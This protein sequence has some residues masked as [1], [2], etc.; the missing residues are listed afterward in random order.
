MSL[1][2]VMI[3]VQ[4]TTL[5]P[6]EREMLQHP[7][8]GGVIL[9]T[10]NYE[11]PEQIIE[12]VAQIHQQRSPH[13]LVA[14]D[15][16]GGRVQRFRVGFTQLPPTAELGAL[17]DK[18]PKA[19]RKMATTCGWLMAVELRAIG[20]DFSFAPVLD[21]QNKISNVIG[22]RA[23]HSDPELVAELAQFY[24]H[25][26]QEAGMATTGKHFP[27]HGSVA[28][29]SHVGFPTDERRYEDIF[30]ADLVPFERMIRNGLAAVMPAHVI[31][32]AIDPNP[33]GFS[34]FWLQ[35][36]LRERLGFNGVIF[37]DDLSMEAASVAGD[38]V[39]RANVA[40]QVG[41]DM[42]LVCNDPGS[43]AKVLDNLDAQNDP[44]AHIRLARMHGRHEINRDKLLKDKKWQ[45][46]VTAVGKLA[47]GDTLEL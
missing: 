25:G 37:S 26:M 24:Q 45:S 10:R 31:Y 5:T 47:S 11:T 38:V 42:V 27:G 15:H 41:C 1:G 2:P 32:S 13:L 28:G 39:A 6:Q 20:V 33:A 29:D 8:V 21:L 12:L 3:D 4:G 18:N 34:K 36:V 14:V 22:D 16:E 46:A 17:Y 19:G 23:F 30:A 43:A 40:L 7:L 44:V 35:E 9:F